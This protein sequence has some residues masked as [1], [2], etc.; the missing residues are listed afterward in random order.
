MNS[1]REF[2]IAT[3][4]RFRLNQLDASSS[5]PLNVEGFWTDSTG[6]TYLTECLKATNNIDGLADLGMAKFRARSSK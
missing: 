1:L 5:S 4:L 2:S 6:D 3:E